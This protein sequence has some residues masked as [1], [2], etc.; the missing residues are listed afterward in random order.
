MSDFTINSFK[1]G[2]DTRRDVLTTQPGALS[3]LENA[4]INTGGEIE[5]R[6]TFLQHANVA[7]NDDAGSN[8]TGTF[9]LEVTDAGLVVF[10]SA[11]INGATITQGQPRLQSV[12]PAGVTY[13]QLKH[14]TLTNDTSETYDRTLHRIT[15]VVF[16]KNF[17]GKA[18][19]AAKFS[20]T[21]I[22]LYYNGSL[23]QQSANGLVMTNRVAVADLSVDLV[24]QIE[25]LA[26]WN[27]TPN[28]DEDN[29]TALNGST[30][31]ESAASNFF[32]PDLSFSST[33]GYA[34]H[35]LI[36]VA[37][38]GT[39]GTKAL[40][41]FQITVNTGPF[42]VTAPLNVDGSGSTDLCGGAVTA[43]GTATLTA[44]DIAKR[45]NDL[46][47]YHGYTALSVTDTVYVYAPLN[48]DLT[49]GIDLT[50]TGNT[51]VAGAGSPTALHAVIDPNPAE[52]TKVV[53]GRTV[54][55]LV[56]VTCTMTVVGGTAPYT[57]AW[58][59]AFPGSGGQSATDPFAGIGFVSSRANSSCEFGT[60][61]LNRRNIGQFKCVV[62]DAAAATLTRYVTVNLAF[63]NFPQ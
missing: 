13:Q 50:V 16:S 51:T 54:P 35:K 42:T 32:A 36:S 19:V 47:S 62:T 11:L 29:T 26:G 8:D 33:S 31:V 21:R 59:E 23:I 10:G 41:S 20:D 15:Q 28:I 34:G 53:V 18:F 5:K 57:Y 44:T 4:S 56:T 6:K 3:V 43:L 27:G 48:F 22:F 58:A 14:P 24:R 46:T 49:T 37:L 25:V 45:I 63:Y 2:L 38:A 30:L 12:I 60:M 52:R 17:N 9:G 61:V 55:T 7:I 1:F 39:N 40:A